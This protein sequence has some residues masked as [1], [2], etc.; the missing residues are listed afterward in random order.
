MFH[1]L[2]LVASLVPTALGNG[3]VEA[4]RT[5]N[6]TNHGDPVQHVKRGAGR[7]GD[8]GLALAAF[9]VRGLNVFREVHLRVRAF[10]ASFAD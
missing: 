6:H 7:G 9:N 2:I 8:V 1:A 10:A 5:R 3:A 4:C